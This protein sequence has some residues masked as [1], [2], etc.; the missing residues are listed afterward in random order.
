MPAGTPFSYKSDSLISYEAGVKAATAD[1]NFSVDV[2][3]FHID[4]TDIQLFTVINNFGLNAN[5]G[6]AKS[7]GVE[8]TTTLRPTRGFVVSLNGAYTRSRLT[9]DTDP[10]VGGLAG[11]RL[12]FTPEFNWNANADYSWSLGGETEAYAG[13][14]LRSLSKQRA[15][16][17]AGFVALYGLDRPVVPAY[18]VIDLRAGIDFRRFTVEVFAK[19]LGN[20]HGVTDVATGGGLPVAPEGAIS[21]GIIRPRTFGI[22]LGAGF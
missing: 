3:V 18:E 22:T 20:S 2:A 13:A 16:F 5:G 11:D 4:W 6:K 7:D 15:N 17:D 21:T 9:T 10:N 8:F 19:N 1:G 12:P 14:S